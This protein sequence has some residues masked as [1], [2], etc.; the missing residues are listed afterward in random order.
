MS[1]YK[2]VRLQG[3][4]N[5]G[6]IEDQYNEGGRLYNKTY[7]DQHHLIL[8]QKCDYA[9]GFTESMRSLGNKA[10]ELLYNCQDLQKTW[11]KENNLNYNND[12]WQ[13]DIL[14]AQLNKIKPNV[15]LFQDIF[16]MPENIRL[17]LKKL[18]PSIQLIV[19]RK[20]YP[21]E[22]GFLGD[23]DILFVSSPILYDRYKQLKPHLVYHSFD[24]SILNLFDRNIENNKVENISFSSIGN[25]RA[26]EHRYWILLELLK[27]TDIEIWGDENNKA[28]GN[29]GSIWL[30]SKIRKK[31]RPIMLDIINF[32]YNS[33]PTSFSF[34]KKNNAIYNK[35]KIFIEEVEQLKENDMYVQN[36]YG[37]HMHYYPE[38]SL[39]KMFPRKVHSAR[40]GLDYYELL[41]RSSVTFNIHSSAARNTVDN[42]RMFEATGV[43][44]CL[45]TDTGTN[46]NEIFEE[47]SEI[48]TYKTMEELLEKYRYLR[49]NPKIAEQIGKAGQARTL[50]EHTVMHRCQQ[51]DYIIKGKL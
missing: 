50:K 7:N 12:T 49:D 32:L 27:N 45:L 17:D 51:M 35:L 37:I 22:R 10:Y 15:V 23:A 13:T 39:K 38:A 44:T 8:S 41:A 36:N 28:Y 21:G 43:G 3:I 40:F 26:P 16:S 14:L 19:I 33:S 25:I 24:D 1:N 20:G 6:L 4:N 48:I 11:A 46:M 34:F 47:D 5:Q 2:I 31:M 9:G 29:N 30:K 42:M 18:V